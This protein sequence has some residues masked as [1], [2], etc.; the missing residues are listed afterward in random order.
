[1]SQTDSSEL[2]MQEASGGSRGDSGGA[3]VRVTGGA[4]R[5]GGG[6][7]KQYKPDQ[8]KATRTGTFVGV[9][10]IIAWGAKFLYDRL[11]VYEG[12]AWWQLL[13][14]TGI[15]ILFAVVCGMIGWWFVYAHRA[16]SDF[17]I[18]TEGE[19]K[20]VSWSSRREIIGSTKVVILF[21]ILL[22]LFL[23]LVD[24]FFQ[25]VFQNLGVLRA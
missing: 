10:L 11:Q 1:M 9:G 7:L 14:T 3:A 24:L 20:K 8:G 16:T 15:P 25:F 19:M 6:L 4:P 18:A 12:D 22:A 21:T 17:M 13:I 2:A 5:G 23:F